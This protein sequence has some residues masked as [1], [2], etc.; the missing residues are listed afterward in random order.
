ME[1]TL[2]G[3]ENPIPQLERGGTYISFSAANTSTNS[4]RSAESFSLRYCQSWTSVRSK[5]SPSHGTFT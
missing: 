4:L 3:T 1:V 5:N 2:L